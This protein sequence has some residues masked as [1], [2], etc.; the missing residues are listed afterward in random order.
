MDSYEDIINI[1][2]EKAPYY[3]EYACKKI[4]K[5]KLHIPDERFID[6]V[7]TNSNRN[8]HVLRSLYQLYNHGNLANTGYLSILPVDQGIEHSASFSFYKNQD[9]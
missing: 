5:E 1:L 2:E 8:S 9:Y 6:E 7:F 3:L 4:S